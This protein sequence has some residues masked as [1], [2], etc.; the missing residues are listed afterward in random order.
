MEAKIEGIR[1]FDR[2]VEKLIKSVGPDNTEPILFD[3]AELVTAQVR[4]N[5]NRIP[6]VTGRLSRSPVTKMM[7]RRRHNEPRPSIAAIDRKIAPHAGL[8]E[9]GTSKMAARPYFRP[10]WDAKR[11]DALEHIKSQ[12]ARNVKGAAR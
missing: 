12:L 5:V 6:K 10:A 9:F 11:K 1:E 2:A 3:A 8:I 4:Q 7:P